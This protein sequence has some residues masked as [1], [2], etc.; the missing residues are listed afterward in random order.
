VG[1]GTIYNTLEA[2]MERS[3]TEELG[4]FNLSST[5]REYKKDT[6]LG[7]TLL[8]GSLTMPNDVVIQY[9]HQRPEKQRNPK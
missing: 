8:V 4:K 5:Y 9:S 3:V 7:S 6:D 1:V 2:S